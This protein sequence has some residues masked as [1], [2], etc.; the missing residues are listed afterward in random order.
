MSPE[1]LTAMV[2][3]QVGALKAFVRPSESILRLM[4]LSLTPSTQLDAEDVPLNH[5]KPHGYHSSSLHCPPSPLLTLPSVLYGMMYRDREVCHAV[6]SGIP[7]GTPVFG[8]AGTTHEEVAKELNLPFV[9]ELYGVSISS[10]RSFN[11]LVMPLTLAAGRQVQQRRHPSNRPQKE[12]LVVRRHQNSYLQPN[13][14]LQRHS[15]N[16]RRG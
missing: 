11:G 1:E 9:A 3:Y 5:V 2:R 16:R 15:S 12:S 13:R 10:S 7:P 14:E 4:L 6:Y 8:L